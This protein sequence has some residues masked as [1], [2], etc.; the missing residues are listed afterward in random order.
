MNLK[1][2]VVLHPIFFSIYSILGVYSINSIEL[3]VQWVVRPLIILIALVSVV[4]WTA[5]QVLRDVQHAGLVTTLALFW[6]FFGHFHRS[7]FEK[8]PFWDS[9]AGLLLALAI[10]TLP[11]FLMGSNW[12]WARIKKRSLITN[13]LNVTSFIVILLPVYTAGN[14]WIQSVLQTRQEGGNLIDPMPVL[15]SQSSRPDVYLIVLDAYG[16]E[17]FLHEVFGFDNTRFIEYLEEKGFYVADKSTANYPQTVLSLSS[18]LN[19]QYLD[20]MTED[21]SETSSRGPINDFVQHS[22]FRQLLQDA[23]YKFVAFSSASLSTQMRDADVYLSM[24]YSDLN[25]FEGL[26]L[27]STILNLPIKYL[28]LNIPS[29][30]YDLHRQYILFSLDRLATIPEESGPK[31]VFVHIMAPHPPFVL[32][33]VGNYIQPDR[34]FN[35]SDASAFMGTH[36]EYVDG[37]VSE[38]QYLN[39]RLMDAIDNIL[40]ESKEPP[41]IIVQGDHGPGS[42][43]DLVEFDSTCPRERYSILNAYYFPDGNYEALYPSITPVNSFRVVINQHFG[44]ELEMLDDKNYYASWFTP[45]AYVDVTGQIQSCEVKARE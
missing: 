41:I 23:G 35:S 17:D 16:R 14:S 12:V 38:I 29:P 37:Y 39:R 4:F 34:P 21:Y 9:P 1:R 24:T 10:W 7:L 3:P 40:S 36:E 33:E 27:S 2:T 5:K 42:Y 6:F 18:L 20:G 22:V 45:Y 11:L 8:S 26:L 19:M 15:M 32:D 31:F 13:F 25:E 30:S 28:D 44:G 43:F